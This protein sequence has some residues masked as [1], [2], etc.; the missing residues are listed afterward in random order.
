MFGDSYFNGWT[1]TP[2]GAAI[3]STTAAHLGYDVWVRGTG[4]TGYASRRPEK[5]GTPAGSYV[6]QI[7]LEPLETRRPAAFVLLEGGLADLT[8]PADQFAAAFR[9]VVQEV[10]K[11]QP[12]AAIFVLGP[13]NV[14]PWKRS[15]IVENIELQAKLCSELGLQFISVHDL[16]P[17]DEFLSYLSEDKTHPNQVGAD[18][19]SERLAA[20]LIR[21]GVKP[22]T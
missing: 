10:R 22:N 9:V 18:I 3:A 4:A 20:E 14:Y 5:L 7:Q 12:E 16:M 19:L 8:V 2:K 11:K 1:G 17:H 6:E 13:A 21:R 15:N